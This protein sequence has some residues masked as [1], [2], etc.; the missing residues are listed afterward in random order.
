MKNILAQ[1]IFLARGNGVE[2]WMDILV[3]VLVAAVYGLATILKTK[4]RK[5]EQA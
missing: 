3:L 1:F 4:K 2:G 5:K